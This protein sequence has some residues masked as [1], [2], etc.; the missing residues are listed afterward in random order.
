MLKRGDVYVVSG[1]FYV[2]YC[3]KI[4]MVCYGGD[5]I[6]MMVCLWYGLVGYSEDDVEGEDI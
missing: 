2:F 1:F 3:C 4:C 5:R 6:G